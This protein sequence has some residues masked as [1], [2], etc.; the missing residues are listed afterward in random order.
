M[1]PSQ[2]AAL[3]L[4]YALPIGLSLLF[5]TALARIRGRGV[6]RAVLVLGL[7]VSGLVAYAEW[8][9][10]RDPVSLVGAVLLAGFVSAVGIWSLRRPAPLLELILVAGAWY[11]VLRG[12]AGASFTSSLVG[13]L[14]WAALVLVTLIVT[15]TRGPRAEAHGR[16][17]TSQA[18]SPTPVPWIEEPRNAASLP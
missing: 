18:E 12:T 3:L 5:A 8:Q 16:T 7:A 13:P 11:F 17:V 1:D 2:L 6:G 10:A 9:L 4:P 14:A 15:E